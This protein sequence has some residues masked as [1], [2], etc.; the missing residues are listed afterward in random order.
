M[1][2]RPDFS[3]PFLVQTNWSP[4][5]LGAVLAQEKVTEAGEVIEVV[6]QFASKK[7]KGPEL[8]YSATEGE[9]QAVL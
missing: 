5:A 9:C 1:L 2:T 7:V 3:K 8:N 4:T 6:I